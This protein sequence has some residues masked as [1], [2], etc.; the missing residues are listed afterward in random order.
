MPSL[1][2]GLREITSLLNSGYPSVAI[3]SII[4]AK[5]REGYSW[6]KDITVEDNSI[7]IKRIPKLNE[8][9]KIDPKTHALAFKALD[10][11]NRSYFVKLTKEE[12]Q[13]LENAFR[14]TKKGYV[15]V[16]KREYQ[17]I[18]L[19]AG[20]TSFFTLIFLPDILMKISAFDYQHLIV[21]V[22][23]VMK[24]WTKLFKY[25]LVPGLLVWFWLWL[26]RILYILRKGGE[27]SI[28]RALQF[29]PIIG[30]IIRKILLAEK[31]DTQ[32]G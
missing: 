31:G 6:A 30:D 25:G 21:F 22:Q 14:T 15:G 32:D 28:L 1:E 23:E 9:S 3:K 18:L 13:K 16:R 26:V 7:T 19:I 29:I 12:F 27:I 4:E 10:L 2:R 20:I 8:L 5:R 17:I 24:D 11:H